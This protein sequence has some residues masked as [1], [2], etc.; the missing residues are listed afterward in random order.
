MDFLLTDEQ[1]AIGDMAGNLF[2]DYCTD[3]RMHAFDEDRQPFMEDLWKTCIETG[4]HS[5]SIPEEFGGSGLGI[6]E[7]YCVLKAQGAA[8]GHVPLWQHQLSAACLAKFSPEVHR[9]LVEQAAAGSCILI[10]SLH[11]LSSSNGPGLY[12]RNGKLQGRAP[13]VEL[14]G[15]AR[16]LLVPAETDAGI[17]LILLDP[18]ADGVELAEGIFTHG[19]AVA[20]V[21][22]NNVSIQESTILPK[23]ALPWLEQRAIASAAALQLGVS[24][25]QIRRTVEYVNDREQFDR[26]IGAFQ[27][28]QMTMADTHIAVEALRSALFQLCYRLDA[29]LPCDSEALSTR[30]LSCEAAHLV[31]HK[32][33][34]VH[35]GVGVDLSYPI[36]RFLYWSRYLNTLLGGSGASLERLGDWLAKNDTLGWKYD[37]EEN[38]IDC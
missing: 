32:T 16:G 21:C 30:W 8:L 3:D 14:A 36:H 1:R 35:G 23:S 7:L 34:H 24:E 11:Q 27:A 6:T 31:G 20:D 4:L 12:L 15:Q 19:L 2:R 28:V 5:L 25:E 22:C 13:V 17:R 33:Q 9:E 26:S 29:Q 10:A 18:K 38:Q 37:L